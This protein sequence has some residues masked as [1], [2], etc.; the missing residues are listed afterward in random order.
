MID[1]LVD[2]KTLT[3]IQKTK[4]KENIIKSKAARLLYLYLH[5][6]NGEDIEYISKLI[7]DTHDLR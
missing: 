4:L 6:T 7:L 5:F 2:Y 3:S 1:E